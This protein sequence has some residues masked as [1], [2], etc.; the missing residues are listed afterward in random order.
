LSL[1][2]LAIDDGY[3]DVR[4]KRRIETET[5]VMVGIVAT[6]SKILEMRVT[7]VTIDGL[8]ATQAAYDLYVSCSH[9]VDLIFLDGVTYAGFNIIDPLRL[10]ELVEAPII[11]VF[12]FPLDLTKVRRALEKHFID[13]KYRY[14]VISRVYE[15]SFDVPTPTK[16]SHVRISVVGASRRWAL[17]IYSLFTSIY[18]DP[19]PLRVADRIAS[20]LG[21]SLQKLRYAK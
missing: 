3:F 18:P 7:T 10:H 13:H 1:Y 14:A 11:V 20:M 15:S 4:N 19:Y 6:P 21:R 16:R 12:R 5:T 2:C 17:S 8:D 9:H